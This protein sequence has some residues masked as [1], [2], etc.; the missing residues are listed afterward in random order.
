MLQ[1]NGESLENECTVT[2]I[3]SLHLAIKGKKYPRNEPAN[4]LLL[5]PMVIIEI[6]ET[7]KLHKI[8]ETKHIQSLR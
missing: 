7:R 3:A 8:I 6:L 4:N 5:F 1:A 2:N